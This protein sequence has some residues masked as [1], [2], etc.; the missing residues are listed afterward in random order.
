MLN[1]FKLNKID[2]AKVALNSDFKQAE[3]LNKNSVCTNGQETKIVYNSAWTLDQSYKYTTFVLDDIRYQAKELGLV[4]VFIT[5]TLPSRF[6]PFTTYKNGKK[7]SNKNYE[8]KSINDGYKELV[9]FFRHLQNSFRIDRKRVKTKY[10][11]VI[12]PHKSFVPHLHAIVWLPKDAIFSFRQHQL[13][14]IKLFDFSMKPLVSGAGEDFKV[15]DDEGYA[16]LYLLKYAQKTLKGEAWIRGWQKHNKL[17]RL[18]TSTRG[19]VPRQVFKKLSQFI[20]YDEKSDLPWFRQM[21]AVT[22]I[23]ISM[24]EIPTL[25]CPILKSRREL[26]S[27]GRDYQ[28]FINKEVYYRAKSEPSLYCPYNRYVM[29]YKLTYVKSYRTMSHEIY[30]FPLEGDN[31]IVTL[32]DSRDSRFVEEDYTALT[33][34]KSIKESYE[35][36]SNGKYSEEIISYH[37]NDFSDVPN[38]ASLMFGKE[39]IPPVDERF[40]HSHSIVDDSYT[41]VIDYVDDS[42]LEVHEEIVESFWDGID[43]E[44]TPKEDDLEFFGLDF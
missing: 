2:Y 24:F 41:I 29:D 43:Y 4:P 18:S 30:H 38:C 7:Y 25:E 19:S 23:T 34:G 26:R 44:Y 33:I 8:N 22:D 42:T 40:S 21:L 32:Y 35:L 39:F 28:V 6:H 9:A 27:V 11:R 16:V 20:K 3:W 14:T 13:N 12:E 5:V 15:L 37:D 17:S 31:P 36:G 10:F 1:C